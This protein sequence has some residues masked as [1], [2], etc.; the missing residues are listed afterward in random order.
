MTAPIPSAIAAQVQAATEVIAQ[1]LGDALVALHL[2]GSAVEPGGLRPLSDIDL[3]ATV[4]RPLPEATR[5]ALMPALLAVSAP[6]GQDADRRALEVTVLAL[7]EVQPWR[8]APRRELQFGEWLRGDLGTGRF[9][10]PQADPDLAILITQLR[11]HSV[12][13]RGPAAAALFAPVPV[14]DVRRAMAAALA[15]W[16]TAADWQG[17]ERNVLLTLA[18]IGYSAATGQFT[19]KDAAADWAMAHLPIAAQAAMA[20]A[21]AEYLGEAAPDRTPW[22]AD[23]IGSAVQAIKALVAQQGV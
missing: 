21:R 11:A 1:H 5:R 7:P 17:D 6:P 14:A 15:L 8:Y 2:Y 13:L 10:A 19:S 3:M 20:Q 4:D 18:R 23:A 16:H 9:E 12:A 22:P